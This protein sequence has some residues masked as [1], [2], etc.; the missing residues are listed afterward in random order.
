MQETKPNH[1]KCF[2]F[3]AELLSHR[4]VCKFQR[5]QTMVVRGSSSILL[6]LL[7]KNQ[8]SEIS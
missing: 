4:I 1:F 2:L 6:I 3:A 5:Y 8:K 7:F